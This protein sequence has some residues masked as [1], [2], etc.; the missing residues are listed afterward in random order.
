MVLSC[1]KSLERPCGNF[2]LGT[3][4]KEEEFIYQF[5]P[6]AFLS[7]IGQSLLLANCGSCYLV[8]KAAVG[9]LDPVTA[10]GALGSRLVP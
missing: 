4:R 2:R 6:V 10:S 1:E 7:F 5:L 9:K 8:P 3:R